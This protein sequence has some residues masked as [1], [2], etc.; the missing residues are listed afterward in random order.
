MSVELGLADFAARQFGSR[1]PDILAQKRRLDPEGLCN[2]G[3]LPVLS[4][5]AGE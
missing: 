2:P 5:R 4:D 3:L 1:L